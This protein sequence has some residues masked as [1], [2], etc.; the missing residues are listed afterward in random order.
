MEKA[1]QSFYYQFHTEQHYFLCHDILE[2]A[3]KENPNFTKQDAVVSLI[4]LAT[5]CYHYRRNNFKGAVT[6]FNR[7]LIVIRNSSDWHTLGLEIH[8]Y[9]A[10]LR[11]LKSL[12]SLGQP[13]SP[14]NLPLSEHVLKEIKT[15]YPNF[16][17]NKNMITNSYI[18]NHHLERDRSEVDNAREKAL[19]ARQFKRE[20]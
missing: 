11:E 1:L 14:V 13:F 9:I 18:V 3:W 19:L 12:A 5:G 15:T 20:R 16:N 7:A 10:L 2:D 8:E 6:S 4:L 17:F